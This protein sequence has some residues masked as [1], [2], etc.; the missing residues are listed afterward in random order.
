MNTDDSAWV[1]Q[2]GW[3]LWLLLAA[4]VQTFVFFRLAQ[5]AKVFR[6]FGRTA[7]SASSLAYLALM[8]TVPLASVLLL[9]NG[10]PELP[11]IDPALQGAVS[12]GL[13]VWLGQRSM[14]WLSLGIVA[15]GDE[16]APAGVNR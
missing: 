11:G 5:R 14:A 4:I 9:A 3:L 10:P 1:V 13:V 15:Q 16:P 8:A 2:C 12:L 7:M 6:V